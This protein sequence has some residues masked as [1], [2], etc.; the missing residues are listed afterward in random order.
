MPAPRP[1]SCSQPLASAHTA[2][3]DNATRQDLFAIRCIPCQNH[4]PVAMLQTA[5]PCRGCRRLIR[6]L[7]AAKQDAACRQAQGLGTRN[8]CDCRNARHAVE[9]CKGL[10]RVLEAVEEGAV[11][12]RIQRAVARER[13]WQLL[14]VPR[15]HH[16][17]RPPSPA[18]QGPHAQ[19]A[20][21][22]ALELL[23]TLS[24]NHS[25]HNHGGSQASGT[26]LL[27]SK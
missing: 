3:G 12:L 17:L 14:G 23:Q 26:P 21:L 15:H 27:M 22:Q 24:C 13:G 6:V 11:Q 8:Q 18:H 5:L 7:Q 20:S 9:E 10:T 2:V 25:P 19:T 1:G 16:T 4:A